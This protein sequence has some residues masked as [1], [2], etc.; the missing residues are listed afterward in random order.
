M[1][2]FSEIG[3]KFRHVNCQLG[4]FCRRYNY[5]F[6][7]V[8]PCELS[9]GCVLQKSFHDFSVR[10]CIFGSNSVS[11]QN[12]FSWQCLTFLKYHFFPQLRKERIYT[13]VPLTTGDL[14]RRNTHQTATTRK[15]R[16]DSAN[17][18]P[19]TDPTQSQG[20]RPRTRRTDF[21]RLITGEEECYPRVPKRIA[22]T[23][24]F[25]TQTTRWW[26]PHEE[27]TP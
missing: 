22:E 6:S 23:D 18:P 12:S 9:V 14:T 11:V 20:R 25:Q 15:R 4:V 16:E 17:C 21:L 2:A 24:E 26:S 13:K 3:M 8:S 7:E 5:G 10:V 19:S 1:Y 27:A